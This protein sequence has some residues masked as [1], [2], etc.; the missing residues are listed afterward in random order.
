MNRETRKAAVAAYKERKAEPGIYAVR[1]MASGQAWVGGAPDLATI[2]NRVSFTLRQGVSTAAFHAV[3]RG[4]EALRR[5]LEGRTSIPVRVPGPAEQCG[6]RA[7][8]LP[9]G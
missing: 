1:C 6:Y 4:H 8:A 2:W 7:Q 9:S 3:L 5:V